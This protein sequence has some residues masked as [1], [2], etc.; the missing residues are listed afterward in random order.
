MTHKTDR[1]PGTKVVKTTV[2]LEETLWERLR[3]QATKERRPGQDVISDA[4]IE[5]LKR[6][7]A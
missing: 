7:K 5:Y 2:V 6:R 1:K 3:N 4:L